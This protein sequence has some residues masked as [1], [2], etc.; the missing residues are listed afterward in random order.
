MR[1]AHRFKL[2]SPVGLEKAIQM[3]PNGAS[4]LESQRYV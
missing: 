4:Q 1:G 2:D 3:R